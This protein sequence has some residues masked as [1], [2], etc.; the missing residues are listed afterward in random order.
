MTALMMPKTG[1]TAVVS[2]ENLHRDHPDRKSYLCHLRIRD[3]TLHPSEGAGRRTSGFGDL[4]G[5]IIPTWQVGVE[6]ELIKMGIPIIQVAA[7]GRK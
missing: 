3:T 1:S 5:Q 6:S 7:R 4:Q 2:Q